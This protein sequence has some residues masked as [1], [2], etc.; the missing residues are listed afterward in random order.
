MEYYVIKKRNKNKKL[1]KFNF[2]E[3]GYV[4]KPNI[5]SNGLIEITSLSITNPEITNSILKKKCDKSFRKLAS[6]I[7]KVLKDEDTSTGSAM[8]A[9]N[10]LEKEKI[11]LQRKYKEYIEKEEREKYLKR[12]KVLESELKEKIVA[13]N[14]QQKRYYEENLEKGHSR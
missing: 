4:F 5:K 14:L 1:G 12:I 13:L 3:K 2:D 7:L 6:M 10:E 11:V 9:L 8:I